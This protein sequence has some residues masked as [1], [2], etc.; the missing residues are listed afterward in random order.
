MWREI[1]I[2]PGGEVITVQTDSQKI[3]NRIELNINIFGWSNQKEL[4]KK[5][6]FQEGG[7]LVALNL[8]LCVSVMCIQTDFFKTFAAMHEKK[9]KAQE[10]KGKRWVFRWFM[11]LAKTKFEKAEYN[12]NTQWCMVMVM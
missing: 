10:R 7:P 12:N 11:S 5:E 4:S 1:Q 2:D 6:K 3:D 8:S 9:R